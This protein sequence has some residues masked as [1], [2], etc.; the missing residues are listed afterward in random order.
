[1]TLAYKRLP[2]APEDID[3]GSIRVCAPEFQEITGFP[4]SQ[5]RLKP[6]QGRVVSVTTNAGIV[7]RLLKGNANLPIRKGECWMGPAT[8]SQL[9][10]EDGSTVNVLAAK[11]Q[12]LGR[13]HYYN[14][15]LNDA[16]RFSFRIGV[17]GLVFAVV[18]ILLTLFW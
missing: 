7:W 12:W 2:Q 3:E 15:H 1:M 9:D 18:S 14:T 17:W 8:R 10:I 4:A 13:F 16:V 5:Y 6:W 11:P